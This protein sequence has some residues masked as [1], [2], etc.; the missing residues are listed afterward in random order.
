MAFQPVMTQQYPTHTQ[1]NS[2]SSDTRLSSVFQGNT[3]IYGGTFNFL[4]DTKSDNNKH[5]T[6]CD[7]DEA[8]RRKYKTFYLYV[9]Q[10]LNELMSSVENCSLLI[11]NSKFESNI[12]AFFHHIINHP[13]HLLSQL[14]HL[15]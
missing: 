15:S 2:M 10:I 14:D 7:D 1:T 6:V 13:L 12:L 4:T 8:V 5:K 9:T 3:Y 11:L